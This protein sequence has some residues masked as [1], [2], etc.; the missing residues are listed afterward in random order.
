MRR[1]TDIVELLIHA[2]FYALSGA[3]FN[4]KLL[5]Q[6]AVAAF[7]AMQHPQRCDAAKPLVMQRVRG[8][9]YPRLQCN[10]AGEDRHT[11]EQ[12]NSKWL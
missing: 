8:N 6:A 7:I 5:I 2:A 9:I 1:P 12:E 4:E 11:H 10:Q 3:V